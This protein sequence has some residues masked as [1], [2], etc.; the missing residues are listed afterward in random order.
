[1]FHFA[2]LL[3][4]PNKYPDI[5]LIIISVIL[6]I[7][8]IQFIAL[9]FF[10]LT[11]HRALKLTGKWTS[12][13]PGLVWL[14]LIPIFG[15]FW[16]IF[17]IHHVAKSV[18]AWATANQQEVQDGGWALGLASAALSCCIIIPFIG[19]LCALIGLICW[20]F[21]WIKISNYCTQ[22]NSNPA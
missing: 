1:M 3:Q 20:I 2:V 15:L 22:M 8:V 5:Q 4:Q 9:I 19:V 12:L 18:K 21:Y 14:S 11:M 13:Q 6:S 17:V 16:Q 10:Q 7:F